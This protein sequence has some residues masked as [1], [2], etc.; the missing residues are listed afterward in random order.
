MRAA[1][2][3]LLFILPQEPAEPTVEQIIERMEKAAAPARG[4]VFVVATEKGQ[5][6]EISVAKDGTVRIQ[7]PPDSAL[8]R[9]RLWSRVKQV[10]LADDAVYDLVDESSSLLAGMS[11]MNALPRTTQR[12]LRS[13]CD[14]VDPF[15]E[16][17]GGG[18]YHRSF[19][20]VYFYALS[21]ARAFAYERGLKK[22]ARRIVDGE[23]CFL[24]QSERPLDYQYTYDTAGGGKSTGGHS[25][26]VRRFFVR[27][28]DYRIKRL[29]DVFIPRGSPPVTSLFTAY[30]N[31]IPTRAMLGYGYNL[32]DWVVRPTVAEDLRR[33]LDLAGAALLPDPSDLYATKVRSGDLPDRLAKTPDDPDVIYSTAIYD[34]NA[35]LSQRPDPKPFIEKL[36]KV[37]A[38]RWAPSPVR[39]LLTQLSA[40]DDREK[41]GALFD[42]IEKDPAMI[43]AAAAE[44]VRALIRKGELDKAAAALDGVTER[45]V[46]GLW[47]AKA[48]ICLRKGDAAGAVA[49]FMKWIPVEHQGDSFGPSHGAFEFERLVKW[50]QTQVADFKIEPVIGALDAALAADPKSAKLHLTRLTI[51]RLISDPPRLADAAREAVSACDDKWVNWQARAALSVMMKSEWAEVKT[52]PEKVKAAL[53]KI[54]KALDAGEGRPGNA[55]TRGNAL[56]LAGE[57]EKAIAEFKKELD[58][59]EKS[60]PEFASQAIAV[61]ES[62]KDLGDDA[63]LERSCHIQLGSYR[64]GQEKFMGYMWSHATNPLATIARLAGEG[65]RFD[66]LYR[67]I[68]GINL[69]RGFGVFWDPPVKVS[70]KDLGEGLQKAAREDKDPAGIRWFAMTSWQSTSQGISNM[71]GIEPVEW[72]ERARESDPK[73]LEVLQTLAEAYVKKGDP[74]GARRTAV[75]IRAAL[76]AG[77]SCA[78]PWNAPEVAL[79]TAQQHLKLGDAAGAKAAMAELDWARTEFE[80]WIGWLAGDVFEGTGEFDKA[81]AAITRTEEFGYK[82][83]YRL[84]LLYVKKE[85]WFEAM[86]QANRAIGEYYTGFMTRPNQMPDF[87]TMTKFSKNR[88]EIPQ[89]LR[90]EIRT[91]AGATF[92]IDKLMASKLPAMTADEERRAKAAVEGLRADGIEDRDKAVAELRALGPKAAPLLRKALDST[93]AESSGRARMVLQEWAEPR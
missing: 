34:S 66:D 46:T 38:K 75:E 31:A 87:E 16:K 44:I 6:A 1:I 74:E 89:R 65:K 67:A 82:P 17:F 5:K 85:D 84:A 80:P 26:Q 8:K 35:K 27:C 86:R 41:L 73:D 70:V 68:R 50:V 47:A 49:E 53:D 43:K 83:S 69:Q 54:H 59:L 28:S 2:L 48:E 56:L 39:N 81:A 91:K 30:D 12:I 9:P 52:D 71:L 79:F 20:H 24:L 11:P 92:F 23:E 61:T 4:T 64:Q 93:D 3:L 14:R 62:V 21:P 88:E 22:I 78:S 58:V 60:G 32:A 19:W 72:L 36:E 13:E 25:G 90:E 45:E 63:L 42:R 18:A 15:T 10:I 55:A 77:A 33:G 51:L 37:V 7:E 40:I 57:K 76:K 29:D